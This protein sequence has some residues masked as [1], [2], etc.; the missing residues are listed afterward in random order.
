MTAI[1]RIR[2]AQ[3]DFSIGDGNGGPVTAALKAELVGIQ[4]GQIADADGWVRKIL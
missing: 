3:G 2:S 4:R 1:G